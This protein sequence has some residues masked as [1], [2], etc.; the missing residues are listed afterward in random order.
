[1][2]LYIPTESRQ[3]TSN[4]NF[5]NEEEIATPIKNEIYV[6]D[7]LIGYAMALSSKYGLDWN[8]FNSVIQQESGYNPLAGFENGSYG[9]A[10]IMPTSWPMCGWETDKRSDPYSSLDC[11]AE[12]WYKGNEYLWDVYCNIYYDEKCINLRGL[13]VGF[14][15]N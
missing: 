7:D 15:N 3:S 14:L 12:Q 8:K 4:G 2:V 13:F 5:Q 9:I 6:K 1:M 10:Q 11:M